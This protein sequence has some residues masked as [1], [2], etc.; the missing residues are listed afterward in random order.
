M[1]EARGQVLRY[2]YFYGPGSSISR[3]GAIAADVARRRLPIVGGG[4]GVWSFIHVD[5]AADATVAALRSDRPGAYNVVDDEPARV[6]EWLPTLA[7]AL[8][9]PRPRAVPAWLARPLAGSY[10]VM[11]MT[12]AQGASNARTPGA[13]RA[14]LPRSPAGAAASA[15]GSTASSSRSTG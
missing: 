8:G 10:G 1:L 9:A 7:A 14:G 3:G 6:S 5:D 13:A 11:T 15:S 2:G 4:G 12:R